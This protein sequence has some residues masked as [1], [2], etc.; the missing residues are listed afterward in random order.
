MA[1]SAEE[2][3]EELRGSLLSRDGV[4]RELASILE[5]HVLVTNP[6]VSCVANAKASIEKL[7]AKRAAGSSDEGS[8]GD[9]S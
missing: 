8:A 4:D 3:L 6:A 9:A 5:S 2:F 1:K 7:A